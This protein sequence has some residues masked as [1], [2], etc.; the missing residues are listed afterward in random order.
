MMPPGGGGTRAERVKTCEWFAIEFVRK[1]GSLINGN[2]GNGGF[3]RYLTK[4]RYIGV[5]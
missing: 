4:V 2:N 5:R 1:I 3:V